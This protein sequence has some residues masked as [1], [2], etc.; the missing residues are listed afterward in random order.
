[1]SSQSNISTKTR[2]NWLINAGVFMGGVVAAISGLYFLFVPSGG[3]QGGRNAFY[4]VRFLFDR[5][6]WSDIHTW[7]G[8]LMI[9][10]VMLHIAIHWDWIKMMAKRMFN[11]LRQR[12][13]SMSKGA[14]VNILIDT[15]I[16]ASFTTSAL[17][18]IYFLF[19]PTGGFQGGRNPGWDP[20]FLW[21]RTTW[22]LIHTWAGVVFIAAAVI[23]FAIHWR[24][25]KKVTLRFFQFRKLQPKP[26]SFS[27]VN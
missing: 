22:D 7:G 8:V 17:S 26:K 25:I 24:W 23:H 3:Y 6:T 27:I 12:G 2:M 19:A 4:R 18:G 13:S 11:S 9:C 10:V 1:M 21:S 20:N 5:S 14:I 16:A 15:L